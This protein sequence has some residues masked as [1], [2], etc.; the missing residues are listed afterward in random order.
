MLLRRQE[1]VR[2]HSI[3][4]QK[5]K[6]FCVLIQT[7]DGE[8]FSGKRFPDQ[9]EDGPRPSVLCRGQD[10]LRLVQQKIDL[11]GRPDLLS[12]Y[13]DVIGAGLHLYVRTESTL[14]IHTDKTAFYHFPDLT[15]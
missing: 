4:R 7:A 5:E 2:K 15:S 14:P 1:V 8:E 6:A 12:G 10:A 11:A 3:V 9:V 13:A